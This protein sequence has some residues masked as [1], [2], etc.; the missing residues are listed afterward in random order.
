MPILLKKI[1]GSVISY[2]G[3]A[4]SDYKGDVILI[5]AVVGEVGL[6][7]YFLLAAIEGFTQN[8]QAVIDAEFCAVT[9]SLIGPNGCPTFTSLNISY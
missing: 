6:E 4:D 3:S 7:D 8:F 2:F 9:P 1:D 5:R